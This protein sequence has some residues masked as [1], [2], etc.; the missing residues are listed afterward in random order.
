MQIDAKRSS[1]RRLAC[2]R[3]DES[4]R[5]GRRRKGVPAIRR[6][7]MPPL[8]TFIALLVGAVSLLA[9]PAAEGFL[10]PPTSS[11]ISTSSLSAAKDGVK[12]D[13]PRP[14]RR[15]MQQQ[16]RRRRLSPPFPNGLCGGSLVVLPPEQTYGYNEEDNAYL[17][18][19]SSGDATSILLPPRPISVWLPPSYE[20]W[21]RKRHHG[22]TC[23]VVQ[24]P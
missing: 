17:T 24:I 4:D 5:E 18:A 11:S 21:G 8:N 19:A 2:Q 14:R 23:S 16:P 3:N 9:L 7:T 15:R 13:V 20:A 10:V 22:Q 12:A 1:F 6:S